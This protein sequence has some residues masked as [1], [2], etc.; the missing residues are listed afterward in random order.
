MPSDH[1]ASLKAFHSSFNLLLKTAKRCVNEINTNPVNLAK[2]CRIISDVLED[3]SRII[4]IVG[5]G[6]SGKVGMILGETLK[7][8]GFANRL[9][10]LGKSLA[11]PVRKD[12]LVI[13]ITGSGWTK[14]TTSAIEDSIRRKAKILTLTGS[15]D[16]KAARLSDAIL[17]IPLGYRPQDVTGDLLILD[18]SAPLTPLGT[19]FELTAMVVGIGVI[20]GVFDGACTKGFNQ[21]TTQVLLAAEKTLN[22]LEKDT[23][24]IKFIDML[25]GFC[26]QSEKKVFIF[27]NGL[28][29]IISA[30]SSIRF[31]HLRMNIQ[32]IYNWRFRKENDLLIAVSGSGASSTTL[33]IVK[34]AKA[35]KMNV[36]GLTSFSDSELARMSDSHL[37]IH[38]RDDNM[39]PDDIQMVNTNLHLP[40]FEYACSLALDA[41][42]AQIA[43]DLGITED[44]MMSEHANIE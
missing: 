21:G 44:I 2:F 16:S 5:M 10:Y 18:K 40:S 43:V 30:M 38:G 22:S 42:V 39:S 27:G 15:P 7:D 12:D 35:S 20:G 4:H 9:S 31:A 25:K 32:S 1:Q 6:R 14:F 36:F 8:I 37:L 26:N 33:N 19:V 13:A 28:D 23:D 29:N 17:K 3:K 11:R 41:C 24:L 34:S